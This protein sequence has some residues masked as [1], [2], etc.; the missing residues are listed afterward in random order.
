MNEGSNWEALMTSH[1]HKLDNMT[2]I[3]DRNHLQSYGKTKEILDIEP[4]RDKLVSFGAIVKTVDGH[5]IKKLKKTL[6]KLPF[7]KPCI[8]LNLQHN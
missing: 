3:I 7:K 4:L 5:D 8:S 1:K 2:I 6:S